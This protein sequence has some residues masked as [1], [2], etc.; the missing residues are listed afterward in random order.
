MQPVET[1]NAVSGLLAD[2]LREYYD[3]YELAQLCDRFGLQLVYQG[4]VLD[5]LHLACRLT[6]GECGDRQRQFLD[7]IVSGLVR[8]C[9]AR[10]SNTT[11]ES[12]AFDEQMLP[13][14]KR[15]RLQLRRPDPLRTPA[16][17][18]RF[19]SKRAVARF[20]QKA[21]RTVTLVDLRLGMATFECLREVQQPLRLLVRQVP[22]EADKGLRAFLQSFRSLG[23]VCEVRRHSGIRER[24]VILNGRCWLISASLFEAGRRPLSF[25]E[26]IEARAYLARAVEKKWRESAVFSA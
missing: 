3:D 22:S 11:W 7:A 4:A 9:Q 14:L 21:G 16:E 23:Y 13:H 8:R 10:I 6:Q 19:E 1:N 15:L 12:N 26:T 24:C 25:I 2:A 20:F 5:H 18:F 17:S